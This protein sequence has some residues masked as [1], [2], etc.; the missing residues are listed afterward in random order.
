MLTP[1]QRRELSGVALLGLGAILAVLL[2]IPGGGSV[3][4]PLHDG[5]FTVLGVGAWL[6]AAGFG[7]TGGA[8][9]RATSGAAA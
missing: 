3:A 1:D 9:C 7:V 8:C 4:G 2:L 5:F 6:V